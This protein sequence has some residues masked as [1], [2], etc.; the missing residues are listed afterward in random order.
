MVLMVAVSTIGF[1]LIFA[2]DISAST[3]DDAK[4]DDSFINVR[5]PG[6]A[7]PEITDPDIDEDHSDLEA[8]EPSGGVPE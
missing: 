3:I 7:V 6:G 1:A 4:N 5:E 2:D 8:R